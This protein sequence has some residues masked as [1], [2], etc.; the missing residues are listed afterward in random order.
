[1]SGESDDSDGSDEPVFRFGS[2]DEDS[3][4]DD[5]DSD[6]D[7]DGSTQSATKRVSGSPTGGVG[8]GGVVG[9]SPDLDKWTSDDD[10]KQR[11]GKPVESDD[12]D[13]GP[14]HVCSV[15]GDYEARA[16]SEPRS[17]PLWCDECESIHKFDRL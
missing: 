13:D 8:Y 15:C 17:T 4:G 3:D 7:D 9:G 6:G 1:M 2:D 12:N 10:P 14:T 16:E 11:W 5:E